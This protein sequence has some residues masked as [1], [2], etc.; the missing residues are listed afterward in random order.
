MQAYLIFQP[1]YKYFK[2]IT[3]TNYISSR[4]STGLSAESI[5]PFSTSDNSLTPL[6][7]YYDYNIRVNL[8]EIF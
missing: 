5:K 8:M 6:I 3:I 2:T 1:V 7:S 4:K